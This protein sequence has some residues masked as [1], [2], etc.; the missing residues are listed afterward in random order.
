ML[1]EKRTNPVDMH[2]L[3]TEIPSR[4]HMIGSEDDSLSE[5]EEVEIAEPLQGYEYDPDWAPRSLQ[6]QRRLQSDKVTDGIASR[7]RSKTVSRSEPEPGSDKAQSSTVLDDVR[8]HLG[9]SY[10]LRVRPEA[11]QAE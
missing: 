5:I 10:N 7:L 3:D 8:T 9:H 2:E 6:L 4:T 1:P 11:A